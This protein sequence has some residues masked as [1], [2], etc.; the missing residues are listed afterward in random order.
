MISGIYTV[1]I[2]KFAIFGVS[3]GAIHAAQTTQYVLQTGHVVK[4]AVIL[5]VVEN[6]KS[7]KICF[8]NFEKGVATFCIVIM[9]LWLGDRGLEAINGRTFL[10]NVRNLIM[11]PKIQVVIST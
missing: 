2:F 6:E 4:L 7:L 3:F 5:E 11:R 9:P 1:V 8:S 10:K